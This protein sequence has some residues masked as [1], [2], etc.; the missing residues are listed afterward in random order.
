MITEADIRIED[1]IAAADV[2]AEE[3]WDHQRAE[4]RAEWLLFNR[5][6]CGVA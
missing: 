6:L 5:P 3:W 2:I 1:E 4:E